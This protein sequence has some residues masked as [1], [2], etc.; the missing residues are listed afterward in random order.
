MSTAYRPRAGAAVLLAHVVDRALACGAAPQGSSARRRARARAGGAHTRLLPHALGPRTWASV[1]ALPLALR[2]AAAALPVPGIT[3]ANE[4]LRS[5][6]LRALL[7]KDPELRPEESKALT[8]CQG[9]AVRPAQLRDLNGDGR[10][11]LLTAVQFGSGSG[12]SYLHVYELRGGRLYPVLTQQVE[13]GFTAETVGPKLVVREPDRTR[14][15]YAWDEDRLLVEDR[16]ITGPGADGAYC[17]PTA[18]PTAKIEKGSEPKV[19]TA[20][21]PA[22]QKPAPKPVLPSPRPVQVVPRERPRTPERPPVPETAP[23]RPAHPA[24][25]GRRGDPARPPGWRWSAYG[26]PVDTAVDGL[27]GLDAVSARGGP[28]CCCS[29]VMAAAARR[30]RPVPPDPRGEPAARS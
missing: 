22:P 23:R 6:D 3:V 4:D 2:L 24:G 10:P 30:G 27:D 14:T 7:T 5:V 1:R 25:G 18:A 29:T 21:T 20:P 15:T 13:S 28:T 9:C 12:S 19:S 26:F 11:E 17:D 16:Q 8:G